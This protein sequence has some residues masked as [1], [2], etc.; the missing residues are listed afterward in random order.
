LAA[1]TFVVLLLSTSFGLFTVSFISID[2]VE[3]ILL[4]EIQATS[5]KSAII[6]ISSCSLSMLSQRVPI[7]KPFLAR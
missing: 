1:L 3:P 4:I 2:A 6:A 5:S 7:L